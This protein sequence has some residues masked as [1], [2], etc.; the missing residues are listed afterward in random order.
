MGDVAEISLG[1]IDFAPDT[2]E[3]PIAGLALFPLCLLLAVSVWRVIEGSDCGLGDL[4]RLE[5]PADGDVPASG[6]LTPV[7]FVLSG[8]GF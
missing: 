3:P 8:P 7:V 5:P 4:G 2:A 1:C 6:F